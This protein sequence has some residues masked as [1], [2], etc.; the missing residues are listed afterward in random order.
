MKLLVVE[1]ELKLGR[2][3]KAGLE[4]D[5]YAVD[6]LDNADDGLAYAE[7]E[8]YDVILLDRMLPGGQDGLD[9]CR[10]IRAAGN[11]TPV[12]ML[13]AKGELEDRVTGLD[14]GADDYLVK[15]FEFEELLARVRALVRRPPQAV[16]LC[17]ALG[18]LAID[19]ATKQVSVDNQPVK[20]SKKEY[21][22]LEYLAHHPDQ[23]TSKDQLIEHVWDFDSDILPNTVEVFIRSLRKKI[24][25]PGR[26][27]LIDTVRGS[28]YRLR[29]DG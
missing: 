22:L 17:I 15:P 18:P 4:Q 9:I 16:G 28:G 29:A 14:S 6:L 12:L 23:V 21:A 1:D 27:S 2:A 8:N 19:T 5:G 13:T 25:H 26:P 3:I 20:L 11:T 24:D 10:T 7:T